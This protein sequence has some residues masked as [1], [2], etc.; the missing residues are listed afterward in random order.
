MV[1]CPVLYHWAILLSIAHHV[2]TAV[3][4]AT[5]RGSVGKT[6]SDVQH[7]EP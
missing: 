7:G 5:Q 4:V 3:G 1:A 6:A 2:G